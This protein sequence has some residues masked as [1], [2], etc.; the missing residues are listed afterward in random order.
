MVSRI[1][2]FLVIG[3][4]LASSYACSLAKFSPAGPGEVKL[5]RIQVPEVMQENLPY[6]AVLTY[7]A[8]GEPKIE[9]VCCR[10]V[11]EE[12]AVPSAS[13][14]WYDYESASNLSIGSARAR[15]NAQG[16]YTNISPDFCQDTEGLRFESSNKAMIRLKTSNF[17][18]L[19]NKIE[20]Y[21]EYVSGGE[22]KETNRVGTRFAPEP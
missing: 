17:K 7:N 20:C 12:I 6:E 11:T 8:E 16:N 15:W 3:G 19:Y 10:W 1:L 4:F 2:V 22:T 18:P 9:R 13:L 5:V 21:A 14:Y